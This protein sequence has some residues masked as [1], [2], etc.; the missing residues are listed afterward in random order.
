MS[1]CHQPLTDELAQSCQPGERDYVIPDVQQHGLYLRVQPNGAKSWIS[2]RT[3]LGKQ[4]RQFLGKASALTIEQ[5]RAAFRAHRYQ[6]R[7]KRPTLIKFETFLEQYLN[8]VKAIWKS[9]TFRTTRSRLNARALPAFAGRRLVDISHAEIATW[10]YLV[11]RTHP[12]TANELLI[13]MRA[14]FN[15]ARSWGVLPDSHQNPAVGIRRNRPRRKA[16]LLTQAEVTSLLAALETFKVRWPTQTAAIAMLLFSGCRRGEILNLTWDEVR[17]DRLLLADS[18]TG[19]RPVPLNSEARFILRLQEIRLRP[20]SQLVFPRPEGPFP[21]NNLD[22]PWMHIKQSAKLSPTLRLHDLRHTFAS[23]AVMLGASLLIAGRLLGHKRLETTAGY[24][25]LL[26]E[27][28]AEAAEQ[29]A[30]AIH[31]AMYPVRGPTVRHITSRTSVARALPNVAGHVPPPPPESAPMPTLR[32]FEPGG[33]NIGMMD[34]SSA[35]IDSPDI[36]EETMSRFI[37]F[38]PPGQ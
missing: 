15:R 10:F 34:F 35:S 24:T 37:G 1:E 27:H 14:M 38:P 31:L 3:V 30:S 19:P 23:H 26:D 9:S 6:P 29:S 17:G 20:A 8:R 4:Q 12:G 11:S 16:Q 33:N 7:G 22:T 13:V 32:F 21:F 36:S 18:K 5:A 28:L 25:Y 2:R